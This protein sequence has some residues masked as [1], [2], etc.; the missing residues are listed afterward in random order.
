MEKVKRGYCARSHRS[1]RSHP[2]PWKRLWQLPRTTLE[3]LP[4]S[5]KSNWRK[6]FSS[7]TWTSLSSSGLSNLESGTTSLRFSGI[8]AR[9]C[10]ISIWPPTGCSQAEAFHRPRSHPGPAHFLPEGR[11]RPSLRYACAAEAGREVGLPRSS[12]CGRRRLSLAAPVCLGLHCR[13]W[14]REGRGGLTDRVCARAGVPA[15]PAVPLTRGGWRG[16]AAVWGRP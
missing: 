7:A 1:L 10:Q 4:P 13:R 16:S 14:W 11:V 8:R 12:V 2:C 9:T 3:R 6:P 15:V 5:V